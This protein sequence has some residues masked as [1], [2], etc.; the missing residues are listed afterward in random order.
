MTWATFYL[1]CFAFGFALSALSLLSGLGRLH[2]PAKLH[3]HF[4]L[5]S[6][7]HG[8]VAHGGIAQGGSH[9]APGMHAH[10]ALT[11]PGAHA[12]AQQNLAGQ[13]AG[14]SPI[15]FFTLMA[16][17]TWFGG[18]G[19]LLTQYSSMWFAL[20]L[21]IA[22]MSGMGGAAIIF[23]F[24]T[25]VVLA[26]ETN[27][28]PEEMIGVLGRLSVGIRPGGTGEMVYAQGGTRHT[29]GARAE[30]G[31]AVRKGTEVVV[32]GYEKGIAY[33]RRWEDLAHE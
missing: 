19:Y 11:A 32:T 28:E 5:H 29:C 23:L 33:V 22:T 7:L 21:L 20:G 31:T 30:D 27:L 10:A 25:K 17:L 18:T 3:L 6:G 14:A 26:H 8:G 24:L 4:G 13:P 16:F 12:M 9:A 15:N 1:I 2:L